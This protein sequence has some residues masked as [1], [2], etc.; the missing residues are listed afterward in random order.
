MCV[1]F[2][3]SETL[4]RLDAIRIHLRNDTRILFQR[5]RSRILS[6]S[7]TTLSSAH[8][9]TRLSPPY[10]DFK[11]IRGSQGDTTRPCPKSQRKAWKSNLSQARGPPGGLQ[12]QNPWRIQFYGKPLRGGAVEGRRHMQR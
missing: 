10:L 1:G 3:S 2:P 9:D 4:Q 11:S 12:L 6:T 7:P 8:K 5:T